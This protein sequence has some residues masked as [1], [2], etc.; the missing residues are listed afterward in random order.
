METILK[1]SALR[2]IPERKIQET[3]KST[4][5]SCEVCKNNGASVD[6]CCSKCSVINKAFL[7]YATANI[8]VKYWRL[9]MA[10]NFKGD[11]VLMDRYQEIVADL[12]KT[13]MDG[14]YI[15]FAGSF[16]LGKTMTAACILKKAVE[17]GF[18]CLY[19]TLNDILSATASDEKHEARAELLSVDFLVIDEFDGRYMATDQS[20]SFYGRILEDVFRTRSQNCLPTFLCTNAPNPLESF[21]GTI[22]QALTSLMNEVETVSVLGTDFRSLKEKE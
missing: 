13:Y 8:P 9:D 19:I 6:N 2:S 7:R 12:K 17:K 3:L 11:E 14:T 20:A 22:Q 1:C 4:L 15:I 10:R 18:S 21:S 16:G 5:V